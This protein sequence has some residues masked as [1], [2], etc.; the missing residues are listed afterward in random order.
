M[1]HNWKILLIITTL[2]FQSCS[3]PS[4][5]KEERLSYDQELL[6]IKKLSSK[7][8]FKDKINPM[9]AQAIR[10]VALSFGARSGLAWR[11][12]QINIELSQTEPELDRIYNFQSMILKDNILPPVLIEARNSL[13]LGRDGNSIRIADTNYEI[14]QQSRFV[15]TAPTWRNYLLFNN[16]M[17]EAPHKTLLPKNAQERA[18]WENAVDEGW[19]AGIEQADLIFVENLNRLKRDYKGMMR[20]KK[21]LAQNMVT[22]PFVA[23]MDLGITGDDSSLSIND[24]VLQINAMPAF[25]ND[26]SEWNPQLVEMDRLPNE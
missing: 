18:L 4:I 12:Q 14:V 15:T 9:K 6:R 20:Y 13:K 21:L 26:S 8:G 11:G 22:E 25:K 17:P 5:E 16:K 24:R 2:L 19:R 1:Q 23:K 10:D 7:D 3:K